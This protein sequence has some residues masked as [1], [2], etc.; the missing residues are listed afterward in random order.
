MLPLAS[1][2]DP[3]MMFAVGGFGL[4]VLGLLACVIYWAI[5]L[6]RHWEIIDL[7]K[8]RFLA[9][10]DLPTIDWVRCGP[11]QLA[12]SKPTGTGGGNAQ[13]MA[14]SPLGLCLRMQEM[15]T[16]CIPWE[17]IKLVYRSN[18]GFFRADFIIEGFADNRMV[19]ITLEST[20]PQITTFVKKCSNAIGK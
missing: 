19:Y 4:L 12:F 9:K 15:F 2:A 14:C 6:R 20:D 8:Q 13:L 10:S 11:V 1:T 18:F 7:L 5:C 17:S 3:S 16:L